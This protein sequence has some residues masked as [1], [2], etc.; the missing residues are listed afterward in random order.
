MELKFIVDID[1]IKIKD[2]LV[3]KGMSR[4][5]R[6]KARVKEN[7][8]VNGLNVKNYHVL[9]IGDELVIK[10]VEKRNPNILFNET[11]LDILYEDDYLLVVNKIAGI[12]SQPSRKHPRDNLISM[13]NH[14]Y[15]NNNIN[16]NFHL[17]NR[18]DF[19][20]T[21]IVIVAKSGF[22]HHA[23]S[24]NILTKQYLCII[25]G[26][27]KEKSGT[28]DVPI[29]RVVEGDIRRGVFEDGQR[30]ITKYNVLKE[31]ADSSLVEVSLITGRTHQIRVHFSYLGHPLVGENLYDNDQGELK[32]HCSL[33]EF[34]HP[35]SKEII[36][37]EQEP[38]W[39]EINA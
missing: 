28:I 38:K 1:D 34:I 39:E 30:S 3:L 5:M 36:T 19:K 29:R 27:L 37:I 6:R 21:G 7:L 11:Q 24:Q 22:I 8:F 31:F 4:N 18:L 14:Y 13:I 25:K 12:A 10:T 20:T 23:M 17:V 26:H 9:H 33:M 35:I 16:S 15:Q 2:F 32:L